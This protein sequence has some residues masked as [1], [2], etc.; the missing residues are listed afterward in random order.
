MVYTK[1]DCY[2]V[3]KYDGALSPKTYKPYKNQSV[4][5][6]VKKICNNKFKDTKCATTICE[7]LENNQNINPLTM[8]PFKSNELN[9]K[10]RLISECSNVQNQGVCDCVFTREE[11]IRILD[12]CVQFSRNQN[13]NPYTGRKIKNGSKTFNNLKYTCK[14]CDQPIDVEQIERE[15]PDEDRPYSPE[16][17]IPDSPVISELPNCDEYI[18]EIGNLKNQIDQL[19]V[20]KDQQL[21]QINELLN[22]VRSL[23][24]SD[25]RNMIIQY[26]EQ[27]LNL[28]REK[29]ELEEIINIM[30][31]K[32]KYFERYSNQLNNSI[33]N[34]VDEINE[35]RGREEN[36]ESLLEELTQTIYSYNK[37]NEEYN[38]LTSNFDDINQQYQLQSSIIDE[39]NN[40]L[41]KYKDE[42]DN[43]LN[44]IQ[45]YDEE[46]IMK[47]T[48]LE[49]LKNKLQDI[50]YEEL[51][52]ENDDLKLMNNELRLENDRVANENL[53][54]RNEI[55]QYKSYIEECTLIK[56][57]YEQL[58]KEY[59]NLQ[60]EIQKYQNKL[61]QQEQKYDEL[62]IKLESYKELL[63][64]IKE[65][66]NKLKICNSNLENLKF[67]YELLRRS[68][69]D[70]EVSL[71]KM[72][73]GKSEVE[74]ELQQLKQQII[75]KYY[76]NRNDVEQKIIEY[77]KDFEEAAR[78][79][80]ENEISLLRQR[81]ERYEYLDSINLEEL[82]RAYFDL[83][84]KL[85]I[86]ELQ[87]NDLK[88]DMNSLRME[89]NDI[90]RK[91]NINENVIDTLIDKFNE[92][93]NQFGLENI[94]KVS[95]ILDAM[96]K[97]KSY[98]KKLK[99]EI[100]ELQEYTIKQGLRPKAEVFEDEL[101]RIVSKLNN[102]IKDN[103][104][105]IEPVKDITQILPKIDEILKK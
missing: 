42:E 38:L 26:R 90:E 69:E 3:K 9:L 81:L 76:L 29:Q 11:K 27:I 6:R 74:I 10:N 82:N 87:I 37:L 35:Y 46:L 73:L 77:S 32:I 52:Q 39:L 47:N 61:E 24:L 45:A 49:E 89:K 102:I 83:T 8:L 78:E 80:Y 7:M 44:I 94:N 65:Y 21:L 62:S 1:K 4:S 60:T 95:D 28:Q 5:N 101:K 86:Y 98:M 34:L 50:N 14:L 103:N 22:R 85:K 41:E 43:Y 12:N 13:I 51:I 53:Q 17:L 93:A 25:D 64:K 16:P 33:Q 66:K 23:E 55:E 79:V 30:R 63:P 58:R 70:K 88:Y 96:N 67:D 31:E 104:L 72:I 2:F 97:I 18:T 15:L 91:Y 100:F 59:Q 57:Q 54:Y 75:D 40:Q 19:N 105:N 20:I 36:D 48:E 84:E 71:E 99:D 56:Q 92:I 68:L